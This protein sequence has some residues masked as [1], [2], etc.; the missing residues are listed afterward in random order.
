[1]PTWTPRAGSIVLTPAPADVGYF[2]T[3]AP[4]SGNQLGNTEIRAGT[5]AS[6][7]NLFRGAI[8]FNLADLP[9][10]AVIQAATLRVKGKG[11][12]GTGLTPQDVW[13]FRLLD[14]AVDLTWRTLSFAALNSAPFISTLSPSLI[15]SQDLGKDIFN[16]FQWTAEQVALLQARLETT[17]RVSLRVDG[18]ALGMDKIFVWYARTDAF[19]GVAPQLTIR[20]QIPAATFTPTFTPVPTD[21]PTPTPTRT[22]TATPTDT[23]TPTRTQTSTPTQTTTP[24]ATQ[25]PTSTATAT[26]TS[27][28][29][30]TASA[31]P[32]LTGTPGFTPS[33]TRTPEA[34]E[35]PGGTP[36]PTPTP[37]LTCDQCD[38]IDRAYYG[39]DAEVTFT[40]FDR[41]PGLPDT[42]NITVASESAQ[43]G[44]PVALGRLAPGLPYFSTVKTRHLRFCTTCPASDPANVTIK[45]ADG[46]LLLAVYAAWPSAV[47]S[48][49]WY[50]ARATE[51][52]PP[53]LVIPT[54]TASATWTPAP[55]PTPSPSPSP[56]GTYAATQ[57]P[58]MTPSATP[59]ATASPVPSA[60]PTPT[61]T[62]VPRYV[63][64]LPLMRMSRLPGPTPTVAPYPPPS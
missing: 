57:P 6:G 55:S 23:P 56:T 10:G 18:P 13:Y 45:V 27:T 11:A 53:T 4:N 39:L 49:F 43:S 47:Q 63:V 22:P 52:P 28:A 9:P 48:F 26:L 36:T 14:P 58:T 1:M 46:D 33:P 37:Y 31:S 59:S 30:P 24:T 17:R 41:T 3:T 38:T 51:T 25:T 16:E 7:A 15:G 19:G 29:S 5:W 12:L 32:M 40:V 34:T 42:V 50:A 54:A 61:A 8:Q 62:P 60:T 35:T 2:N 21:T 64:L 20:Y 44:I